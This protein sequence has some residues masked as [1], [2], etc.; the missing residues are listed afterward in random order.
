MRCRTRVGV[1]LAA[2]AFFG[3][4]AAA[5]AKALVVGAP[6][7]PSIL[8]AQ[9]DI[10]V[11]GKV[12]EVEKD[13]VEATPNKGAPKDQKMS[14]KIAVVKVEE[15]V[16]GG[17]G[18]TQFR[19]GFPEGAA[20]STRPVPAPPPGGGVAGR[21]FPGRM[22]PVALTAG[23]EGC[24]FLSPHHSGDFYIVGSNGM[25]P[26]LD[27]K[28]ENYAKQ[29]E[30]VKKV[31]K[32]ID[33]PV[34]ALKAKAL[35]DRYQAAMIILQRYQM[36]RG[37]STTREP[38]PAEENKL[39][40]ALLM[41]LPW[42]PKE[43]KPRIGSD[44][45]PLSRSALWNMINPNE[46]GYRPPKQPKRKAGD[47]PPDFNKIYDEATMAFLKENADKIKIKRYVK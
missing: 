26:P 4:A 11:I 34:A 43:T 14:Y 40:I 30:E 20:A 13:T 19:V 39:I 21:P 6:A 7:K 22:A 38:I 3:W 18:L 16:I 1:A 37:G 10:V 23:Q 17:K 24:F 45:A 35:D 27:K 47:P 8:A 41:E 46:L 31:A 42:L 5:E 32:T 28:A 36:N 9:S 44:P 33:D 25:A 15:S 2:A 29:L 12:V